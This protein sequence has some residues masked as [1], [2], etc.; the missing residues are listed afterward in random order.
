M[1]LVD[2]FRARKRIAPHVRR[3]PLLRSPWLSGGNIDRARLASLLSNDASPQ[4]AE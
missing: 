1:T 3:T 4:S 2:V